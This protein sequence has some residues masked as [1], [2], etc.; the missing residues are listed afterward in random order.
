MNER[1]EDTTERSA[2]IPAQRPGGS[3]GSVGWVT[4][5]RLLT[6]QP[7]GPAADDLSAL[8][9]N[10]AAPASPAE[11]NQANLNLLLD[12]YRVAR[13]ATP[14]TPTA[15]GAAVRPA[16]A[17]CA[18]RTQRRVGRAMAVKCTGV[19]LVAVGA[20]AA[21]AGTDMLP[22][23]IQRVAHHYFGGLGIPGP[24]TGPGSPSAQP[25]SS[26][27]A[28]QPAGS[29]T[30]PAGSAPISDLIILCGRIPHG[31]KNWSDGLGADDQSKLSAAAGGALKV[32]SYCAQLLENSGS[33]TGQGVSATPSP[34][35]TGSAS[36]SA[37][38]SDDG[39]GKQGKGKDTH[40]PSPNTHS[41]TANR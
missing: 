27:P 3:S 38:P 14:P 5:H 28:P 7:V 39:S 36:A 35:A 37:S 23:S 6:G 19:L 30:P 25:A 8:L 17:A 33:G 31:S 11:H 32:T 1:L 10:A 40:S 2:A 29:A 18:G 16:P 41:T 20:G 9:R 34:G 4:A 22:A 21:A 12:A 15:A 26:S 13:A 24:S